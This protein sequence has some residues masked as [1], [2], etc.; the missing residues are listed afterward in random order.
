MVIDVQKRK[1]RLR[2]LSKVIILVT[3]LLIAHLFLLYQAVSRKLENTDAQIIQRVEEMGKSYLFSEKQISESAI[4]DSVRGLDEKSTEAIEL[5]TQELAMRLADFLYERDQDLLTLACMRPEPKA[6][7]LVYRLHQRQ[8]VIPGPW[9]R[10]TRP[11]EQ[12]PVEWENP[13][14]KRS[15]RNCPPLGFKTE[16]RPLYREITLVDLTGKEQIKITDGKISTDLRDISDKRNTYCRAEDYFQTLGTLG[17]GD[18]YVS[19]VIGAYTPGW[20]ELTSQGV[21]IAPES[22]YAGKENPG[23]KRFEGIVRWATPVYDE[24]G[25]KTGYVTMALDHTHIM[26]FTDHVVPT[27]ERFSDISDAGSGNYAWLWDNQGQCISHPRDF[28][29]YGFDPD[30]G[31]KVPGWLSQQTYDEYMKSGLVLDDF[32]QNLP[33]FRDFSFKKKPAREQ[34]QSGRIPLCCKV[35]DMAPQCQGWIRGAQKGG[36]G[37]FLIF[38]S[39]LWKLTTYAAIPYY[40]GQYG[41][42][43]LGFGYVTL[44]ANV[45]D[46]HKAAMV[47]KTNIEKSITRQMETV[48]H[49]NEQTWGLIERVVKENKRILFISTAALDLLLL[50][51]LS[52]YIFRMLQPLQRLTR[53]AEAIRQGE[54]DQHINVYSWDEIGRLARSFNEMAVSLSAADKTKSRLMADQVRTNQKLTQEIEE[55]KK[56]EE[57]L[58][59]IHL[60]LEQRVEDRTFELKQSNEELKKATVMAEAASK[61]KGDFLA[62]MSHEIRTPLNGIIGMA[63]LAMDS[64]L[65]Y[66]A[67]NTIQVI[68]TEADSLLRIV[69]DILDFSKIEAG[70][71]ELE[72]IPF[73]IRVLVE[74]LACSLTW[75]AERKG[76]EV[77]TFIS[78]DM[79]ESVIG[80]P[81]RLRQILLNLTGNAVKFTHEG[82][83]FLKVE[84][85]VEKGSDIEIRCSVTDTGIGISPDKQHT[86]F[87]SFTQVDGSTTRKYGGTGLGITI[88]KQLVEI[89]GG[90][91]TLDSVEGK[92]STFSFNVF[93]QRVKAKQD[94]KAAKKVVSLDGLKVLIVS[95]MPSNRFILKEYLKHWGSVPS[96]IEDSRLALAQMI[97]ALALDAPYDLILADY[98]MPGQS[99][100]DL[101][102]DIRTTPGIESVPIL[103]LSSVGRRGDGKACREIGIQGYLT[104][105]VRKSELYNA[106]Q[107]IMGFPPKARFEETRLVTRHTL[108]EARRQTA[109]ILLVEDYPT[110]QEIALSHLRSAGC[111]VDLAENGRQAVEAF[112]NNAYDIVLMDIQMP[113]MDGYQA[114]DAI[115]N[116]ETQTAKGVSVPIIAMTAHALRGYREKCLAAGM[117]D[118][119]TKP[120]KRKDLLEMVRR[121]TSPEET[122]PTEAALEA[123]AE[124][125]DGAMVKDHGLIHG[126]QPLDYR[127]ALE[128]FGSDEA[129][130]LEVITGFLAN[131]EKQVKLM[132]QALQ[133]NDT[134]TIMR[135]SHSIKGAAANLI[136]QDL[137][138]ASYQLE[139]AASAKV[140]YDGEGLLDRLESELA[141]LSDFVKSISSGPLQ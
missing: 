37:S 53:G 85:G 44:G 75:Q 14:N 63:E 100:L 116:F 103:I 12:P 38:W 55:R 86:I 88:C 31:R 60:E 29:I 42:S 10:N 30:T 33:P 129:F 9:P 90:R 77:V 23:G 92:G 106:I 58:Q 1:I 93:F 2:L 52:F 101:A 4:K 66:Q 26:E 89:M 72:M 122:G 69:N 112:K 137:F 131:A 39:G 127:K 32:I 41:Q 71:L 20:L 83:I 97:E 91:I 47:S 96:E 40:T 43:G 74:D 36:S 130:L 133:D 62:N 87:D 118:F 81:G 27:E 134:D 8:V 19:N 22:A 35:L 70:M 136:A 64:D 126:D 109:R 57:A 117:D 141:R 49:F 139:Q 108:L 138:A 48:T 132:R 95:N 7:Q 82:E 84:T 99:G 54:L 56:A 111:S 65:N 119:I 13:D 128:E 80:D 68:S 21:D 61:A 110:N 104:K 17:Q 120:L 114:T 50:L 51:V 79:P 16:L 94:K 105:P 46:F 121:W 34:I 76:L 113:E 102:R 78:N 5:R 6:Y 25:V 107:A 18:I 123:D 11:P 124:S 67:R 98:Q 45:K 3:I 24:K 28:F 125:Q 59:Q 73:N 15:W 115:R 140:F 135:E